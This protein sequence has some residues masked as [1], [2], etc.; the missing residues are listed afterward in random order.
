VATR[1]PARAATLLKAV[2]IVPIAVGGTVTEVL[3]RVARGT[4]RALGS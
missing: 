3:D 2:G 4:L 1:I